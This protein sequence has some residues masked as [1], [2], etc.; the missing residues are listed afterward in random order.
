[1]SKP[2]IICFSG[3]KQ[4]GKGTACKFIQENLIS[5]FGFKKVEGNHAEFRKALTCYKVKVFSLAGPLKK[6][7]KEVLGLTDAQLYGTD[8]EKNSLTRYKWED[9]PHYQKIIQEVFAANVRKYGQANWPNDHAKC[10]SGLMS[11]RQVIQEVGTGV[12]R[13]M[14]GDIW[15]EACM[16]EIN[17]SGVDFAL[18]D[19]CRFPNEVVGVQA[20]GGR[21]IRL[22][23]DVYKGQDQHQSETA[24]NAVSFD[25]SKFDAVIEND[26]MNVD[27][28]NVALE[29][30]L[31]SLG[32]CVNQE[33]DVAV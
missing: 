12:F 19:D 8:E 27:E 29:A 2:V 24:L 30:T 10:P 14:Y 23:R 20:A 18:I 4:G 26:N 9:L 25:W 32:L 22:T 11:A 6:L 3:K 28:Q 31:R 17:S 21:V 33:L 16:R 5:L 15:V 7:C 1:M 13:R